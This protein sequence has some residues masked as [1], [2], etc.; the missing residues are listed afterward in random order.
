M[1]KRLAREFQL[2]AVEPRCVTTPE[3][4][5]IPTVSKRPNPGHARACFYG[6][7]VGFSGVTRPFNSPESAQASA[8]G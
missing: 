7:D 4:F 5:S 6:S 3:E 1:I 8:I 2:V